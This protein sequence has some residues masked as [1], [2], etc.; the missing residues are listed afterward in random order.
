MTDFNPYRPGAN[1]NPPREVRIQRELQQL[2][3]RFRHT[4]DATDI[5][6]LRARREE[7]QGELKRLNTAID[8]RTS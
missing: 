7:L 8:R 6:V 4:V 1:R 2:A 3:E 5:A